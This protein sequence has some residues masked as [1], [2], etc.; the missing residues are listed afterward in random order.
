MNLNLHEEVVMDLPRRG[1]SESPRRGSSE[2]PSRDSYGSPSRDSSGSPSRDDYGSPRESLPPPVISPRTKRTYWEICL[3]HLLIH[4]LLV[5]FHK[6]FRL[7]TLLIL[8]VY[9]IYLI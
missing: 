4:L 7:Q 9:L 2:S 5:L 3:L 8:R 1:R 6:V